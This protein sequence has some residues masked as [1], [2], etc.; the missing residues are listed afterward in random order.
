MSNPLFNLSIGT[1][2]VTG[3]EVIQNVDLPASGGNEELI[4]LIM[5]L[6]IVIVNVLPLFK[7]KAAVTI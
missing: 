1:A 7:K 2:S 3:V 4:K 6:I 5:Q